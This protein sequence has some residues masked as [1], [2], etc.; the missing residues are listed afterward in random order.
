MAKQWKNNSRF[1]KYR[2]AAIWRSWYKLLLCVALIFDHEES[3]LKLVKLALI[4]KPFFANDR[5]IFPRNIHVFV[6]KFSRYVPNYEGRNIWYNGKTGQIFA[7]CNISRTCYIR[8]LDFWAKLI[9]PAHA[10]LLSL[11]IYTQIMICRLSRWLQIWKTLLLT[12][13]GQI[14]DLSPVQ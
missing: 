2:V 9:I 10:I 11:S 12:A 4:K 3:G 7:S 5:T 1:Q 14:A 13:L 8:Q 6:R